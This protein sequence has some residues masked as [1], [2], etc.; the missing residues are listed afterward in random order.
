MSFVYKSARIKLAN[1]LKDLCRTKQA[2]VTPGMFSPY[3]NQLANYGVYTGGGALAGAGLGTLINALRGESK[4]KG[5]LIG[6]GLGAAGGAGLKGLSDILAGNSQGLIRDYIRSGYLADKAKKQDTQALKDYAARTEDTWT[7]YAQDLIFGKPEEVKGTEYQDR[8]RKFE[9]DVLSRNIL[10]AIR[11]N[12]IIG[13]VRGSLDAAN[14][15][16]DFFSR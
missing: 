11:E 15:L 14:G 12:D 16:D 8:N 5:A 1:N 7:N 4:L 13:G 2:L 3:Q 6:G 10:A 9:E